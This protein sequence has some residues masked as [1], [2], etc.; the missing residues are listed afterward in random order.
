MEFAWFDIFSDE[1]VR[2][3]LKKV[4]DW[5][6]KSKFLIFLKLSLPTPSSVYG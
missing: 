6:S 3:G 4:N 2:Q 5:P 1:D